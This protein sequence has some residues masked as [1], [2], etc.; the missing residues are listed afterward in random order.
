[1]MMAIP[2]KVV[3][4]DV[5]I[6]PLPPTS[7]SISNSSKFSVVDSTSVIKLMNILVW[8]R[9]ILMLDTCSTF[10]FWNWGE[11]KISFWLVTLTEYELQPLHL[12]FHRAFQT[13]KLHE[14]RLYFAF[15]WFSCFS[16]VKQL[17]LWKNINKADQ[18]LQK[19]PSQGLTQKQNTPKNS[20]SSF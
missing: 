19:I 20:F 17:R 10:I 9:N 14:F 15:L 5:P 13:K 6:C 16:L 11:L 1:M 7:S 12:L 4:E 2:I 8:I 3:N 18:L